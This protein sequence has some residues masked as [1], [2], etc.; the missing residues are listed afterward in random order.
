MT[1]SAHAQTCAQA[2]CP[3]QLHGGSQKLEIT[4]MP[5]NRYINDCVVST[6]WNNIS[7]IKKNQLFID[8]TWV[9][10]L[11]I[12]MLNKRSQTKRM[13]IGLSLQEIILYKQQP[14]KL[15]WQK[16]DQCGCLKT[17]SHKGGIPQESTETSAGAG[18]TLPHC[19]GFRVCM[20]IRF[21]TLNTCTFLQTQVRAVSELISGN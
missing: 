12:I 3:P 19:A 20:C 17:G 21:Y 13:A 15:Q 8:T 6:Q 9:M 14:S 7:V 4:Q 2:N 18:H 1:V 5:I 11:N 10:N 16:A